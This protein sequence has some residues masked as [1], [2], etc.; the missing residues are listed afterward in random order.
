[1]GRLFDTAA[2]LLGFTRECT[3]EGQAAIWLEN[4]ARTAPAAAPYPFGGFDYEPLLEAVIA[5]RL[6]GRPLPEIARAFH[7]AIAQQVVDAG[8]RLARETGAEALV[9]SGGVFQNMLLVGDIAR[10][11]ALRPDAPPLWLNRVVPPNDGGIALG[12]AALAAGS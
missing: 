6:A 4:L 10:H 9:L 7:A 5:D 11:L 12:Q 2:A 8:C 3:Y 1:M